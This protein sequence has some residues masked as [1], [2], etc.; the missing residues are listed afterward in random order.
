MLLFYNSNDGSNN[1]N[2]Y[3]ND[4]FYDSGSLSSDLSV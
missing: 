2:I 3:Y 4:Y 1:P